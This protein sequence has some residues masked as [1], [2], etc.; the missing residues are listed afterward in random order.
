MGLCC[1]KPKTLGEHYLDE[2]WKKTALPNT[3][4]VA[5]RCSDCHE[6]HE[7]HEGAC[8]IKFVKSANATWT[9]LHWTVQSIHEDPISEPMQE[10]LMVLF[11]AMGRTLFCKTCGDHW[12]TMIKR[13]DKYRHRVLSTPHRATCFLFQVHNI[14]NH[15]LGHPTLSWEQYQDMYSYPEQ[16]TDMLR[17]INRADHVSVQIGPDDDAIVPLAR[18]PIV[19]VNPAD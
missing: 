9:Y 10:T 11:I 19:Q 13:F 14:W 6:G 1:A 4:L 7:G 2:L 8:T 18:P 17:R 12:I 16:F 3:H 15:F 5:F